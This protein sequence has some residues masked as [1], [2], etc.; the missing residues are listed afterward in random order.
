MTIAQ[1]LKSSYLCYVDLPRNE[2]GCNFVINYFDLRGIDSCIVS[3]L[4][5]KFCLIICEGADLC[6]QVCCVIHTVLNS[7]QIGY[8]NLLENVSV[9]PQAV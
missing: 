4:F 5:Y 6:T 8:Y 1:W 3:G 7:F 2:R 9:E